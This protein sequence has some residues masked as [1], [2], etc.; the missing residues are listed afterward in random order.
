[1]VVD[2]EALKPGVVTILASVSCRNDSARGI[3]RKYHERLWKLP[4][5]VAFKPVILVSSHNRCYS[6]LVVDANQSSPCAL[7]KAR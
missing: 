6:L 2:S 3:P 1:M 7:R 5:Q 4:K